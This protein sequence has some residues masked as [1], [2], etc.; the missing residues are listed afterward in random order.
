[1]GGFGNALCSFSR[2][3]LFEKRFPI[4]FSLQ[5]AINT[6]LPLLESGKRR[7]LAS[8]FIKHFE[9]PSAFWKA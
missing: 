3:T 8:A 9:A 4:P 7:F 1:V 5:S 6:A 2:R